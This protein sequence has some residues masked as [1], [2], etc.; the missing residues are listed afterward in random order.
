MG[1]L[2]EI[3]Q[4]M[5]KLNTRNFELKDDLSTIT[6]S[7]ESALTERNTA[8]A[9]NTRLQKNAEELKQKLV[10][11]SNSEKIVV[12]RLTRATTGEIEDLEK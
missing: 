12:A 8:L 2:S 3:K 1:K 4:G 5:R 6:G 10:S 11:L 7:L 9:R